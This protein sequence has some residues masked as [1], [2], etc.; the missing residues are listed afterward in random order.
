MNTILLG[1]GRSLIYEGE[2][3]IH[4]NL[5]KGCG[6]KREKRRK[7]CSYVREEEEEEEKE[8]VGLSLFSPLP[9]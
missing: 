8:L 5:S 3:S 2:S 6:E 9:S 1:K 7:S 4:K